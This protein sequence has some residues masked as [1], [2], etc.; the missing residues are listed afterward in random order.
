MQIPICGPDHN[1]Y[2]N[3]RNL[4]KIN[5][6]FVSS[7]KTSLSFMNKKLEKNCCE[8]RQKWSF[9]GNLKVLLD[10]WEIFYLTWTEILSFLACLKGGSFFKHYLNFYMKNANLKKSPIGKMS[11]W[12]LFGISETNILD[13]KWQYEMFWH[14]EKCLPFSIWNFTKFKLNLLFV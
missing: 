13:K 1:I 9:L 8:F 14:F 11:K 3:Q 12:K 6:M 2:E 5:M 7:G 10:Q 4:L